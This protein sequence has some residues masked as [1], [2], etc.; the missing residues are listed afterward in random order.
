MDELEVAILCLYGN[1]HSNINKNDA[2]KYCENFQNS[3]DCW[4]YCMSKF[5]ESNKLEVKFFCIH[6]IVEKISTLK[7]EDMIL[8]KNSLY[9]YIEKKYVNANEDSCVLNK[10]I[11]L[12]LYLIEF[13]YPH[14]MND[15]FKYLINLIMLN[16]DIN[17]KTI[18]INFFLKLMNMF[19]SEYIDNVCSN[20]SIQTTTNIK[21][22]IKENDL[23]I[24]IECFYYIMNM[25]IP[26]S[27]SLSIFTLSKYVPWI[28][29]NYVVNDK[30]LTY[31]YQTLNTTNSIT[32]A[33]YSFLTSLIRKGMNSA[34]KI[35]FIESINII[36]ILQNTPKITDLTFDVNKNIM[37]KRG[38]LINYICLELVESIFEINK[39]KDYQMNMLKYNEICTKAAD[40]LF[41]VL[42]HALDIFSVNDFY[43]ASTV[44]KFFSLFFTKFKNVI[45]VGSCANSIMK[46]SS[47]D[48]ESSKNNISNNINSSINSNINNNNANSGYKISIDK[49][50]VFINTL[51]CTIVNKFEYPE[52]I[53]DDYDEEEE[54]DDEFST[55]FNF[56]ENIEKLYQRLILFDKLKAIEIIKNAIIYLNEN[57][58]NLKWNNI[59]S[60]LYAFY[61]T[62]SIYCEYKQ[63]S[64]NTSNNLNNNMITNNQ[65]KN[66]II[67]NNSLEHFKNIKEANEV[68]IDYNNLLFDCLIELLKNRKILNS[69]NYHININLMEIFQRL[70]LFF[71]KNPNYIE[72]ALHIFLTNGIRS[73]NN[74]IAKKSVH[75]FKK[76]L[77]TNSSVISNYIKDILQ[78]LESYLDVPYIYPKMD[79]NNN[80]L[81]NNNMILDDNTIKYIYT[82][83]YSNKNYNHEYQIDIYEII[84]LL[85]LN[86][87]FNKFKKLS[88]TDSGMSI[89]SNNNLSNNL[90]LNNNDNSININNNNNNNTINSSNNNSNDGLNQNISEEMIAN[91]KDRIF[92]FKGILNKLLENLSAVKNLYLN[93]TKTQHDNICASF[94]SSVIIKCIGALCKNV[95]INITDILLNDL[96]NTLGIIISESLELFYNNYIVRDS[97]L[98]TYRILSNLFKDLS[99]NYTVKILP[100][101]YNISYNM[102]MNK[103]QKSS[104]DNQNAN[105]F[106]MI[107]PT[108]YQSVDGTTNNPM[109]TSNTH[110]EELKYLYNELNEL[111][112]LVCHLI[113]T[114]KEKSFD[115]FVN[116]Y[117]YNITQI[118]MNIW[119]FINVQSLEMQREQN[120]VLSP[121]LLILY[122]ISVNIPATIHSFMSFEHIALNHK[123][124]C[125]IFSN[126]DIIKS[127]IADA[128]TSILL[129]SLNYK[130][131]SDINI[132]LY[133]AQTL[134]NMLNNATCMTNPSEVLSKYPIMQ[135]ID[136][137]CVTL[138]SLDYADPKTKRIMQEVMNIFRLFCGFK[139]SANCLPNKIIE[140]SQICLQNSLL[141]VFKN[142]PNDIAILIQAINANNQQQFR[143]ILSNIVA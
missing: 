46:S 100:Y 40:M 4:K 85:L 39:L 32:E 59:E 136:T 115:T 97:V 76:F 122:N 91:Y 53:P 44:E 133:S 78:L 55:F 26:E 126:D 24:I 128:I 14:N 118:H 13:L 98:F 129:I 88:K 47:N 119:K 38:E 90:N 79:I 15:A 125:D 16:N 28:D 127:K 54:D 11:Q 135:I 41:L 48:Y 50:N 73:N 96:D 25:N 141:S 51:I 99:L 123:Q 92:F 109:K 106:N 142:N 80:I 117:I 94:I 63:G 52:C 75:I 21:E 72:Y 104:V 66:N 124:F 33:S 8:I 137:L 143:Q 102:I 77:K 107:T 68:N 49:L 83:L 27:T 82:F 138:K 103:L 84:G 89:Q 121:L 5:L 131:T 69:T 70:N 56:R 12:Y 23:P 2:Q 58:D 105:T 71:I 110:H 29:I 31:I 36:C 42:P 9:G 3:A 34:N 130:N 19:D 101:F 57:Y 61:V 134:S 139:V 1:E 95:N 6:V 132:C 18:H 67:M 74:K 37:T 65:N 116:P 93:S 17:I 60:K 87:D 86:Y 45:D 112:I 114:H 22:A 113:S 140:S 81:N 64:T 111:S 62:T 120:A 108:S 20:K 7:I 35:Q 30:I 43:I 10:I